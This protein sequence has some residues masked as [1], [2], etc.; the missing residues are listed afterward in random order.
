MISNGI[1]VAWNWGKGLT[2]IRQSDNKRKSIGQRELRIRIQDIHKGKREYIFN[3][4]EF[5][6]VTGKE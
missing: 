6:S 5:K 3:E 4:T 1:K 2:I